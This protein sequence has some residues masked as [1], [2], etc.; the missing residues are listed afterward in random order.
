MFVEI[1][2]SFIE[3]VAMGDDRMRLYVSGNVLLR[4][5][6]W[7]RLRFLFREMRRRHGRNQ[8]CLDFGGGSGVFL[9]SLARH[10]RQVTC[11]D[12]DTG[13]AEQV[14]REYGLANVVMQRKD[15]REGALDGAP[16]DAIVAADVLEH[17]R[18]VAPAAQA[19]RDWL[20]E[21]GRLYTSLPTENFVYNILR[22]VFGVT[23]PHDHYHTGYEVEA[24]LQANGFERIKRRYVP[25]IAPVFP[26]FI[27]S[28]WRKTAS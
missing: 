4:R 27:I 9:P 19:L 18:D 23:K 16:F 6:F 2:R 13:E 12:L 15:I 20:A 25:L 11:V 1:P 22:K 17:F 26:L 7:L 5:F 28:V 10:F 21:D 24:F 14:V 8:R 3:S